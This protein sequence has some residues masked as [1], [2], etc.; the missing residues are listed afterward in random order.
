M[1]EVL[2]L[3]FPP[4]HGVDVHPFSHHPKHELNLVYTEVVG[5]FVKEK[6]MLRHGEGDHSLVPASVLQASHFETSRQ[7]CWCATMHRRNGAILLRIQ[8]LV[9]LP[10]ARLLLV[11]TDD[12]GEMVGNVL[13]DIELECQDNEGQNVL[14]GDGSHLIFV[15]V[16]IR[17]CVPAAAVV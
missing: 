13:G 8:I 16:S 1:V 4:V 17:Y 9:C 11:R 2:F 7:I 5:I 10:C 14:V 15:G 3:F 12:G 6:C